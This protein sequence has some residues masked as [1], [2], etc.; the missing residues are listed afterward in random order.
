MPDIEHHLRSSGLRCTVQRFGV[1]KYLASEP[2]HATADEI[3]SAL[4]RSEPLVSRATVYNT[5]KELT[6][7]GLVREFPSEGSAARYDANLHRHHHFVCD[8][9]G[10]VEDLAWF[11]LP[12]QSDQAELGGHSIRSYEVIFRGTCRRCTSKSAGAR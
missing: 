3:Y 8:Q 12:R 1:L 10:G 4:N 5:L 11:D 9:C 2:V 7:A 6:R